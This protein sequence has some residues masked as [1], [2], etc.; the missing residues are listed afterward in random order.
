[1]VAV[2]LGD[3]V[4]ALGRVAL[5]FAPPESTYRAEK[6]PR[7]AEKSAERP[8]LQ[9]QL[10][11]LFGG[12]DHP[13]KETQTCA[14]KPNQVPFWESRLRYVPGG[15]IFERRSCLGSVAFVVS[16][17]ASTSRADE[18]NVGEEPECSATSIAP[19]SH[20]SPADVAEQAE[21]TDARTSYQRSRL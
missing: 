13:G 8:C 7:I 14:E 11:Y 6:T 3:F 12:T 2:R 19:P 5:V 1:M 16:P 9:A 10:G 15:T 4:F 21:Q 18:R 20:C 17:L